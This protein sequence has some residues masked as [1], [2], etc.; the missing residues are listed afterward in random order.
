MPSSLSH[1]GNLPYHNNTR[2]VLNLLFQEDLNQT[3]EPLQDQDY[4]EYKKN[5]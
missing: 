5:L 4:E 3:F 1:S 2:I